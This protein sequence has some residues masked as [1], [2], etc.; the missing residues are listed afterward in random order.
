M[1]TP[2]LLVLTLFVSLP[3]FAKDSSLINQ[4]FNASYKCRGF[5]KEGDK[6]KFQLRQEGYNGQT[7]D[8]QEIR[9]VKIAGEKYGQMNL[10]S[11]QGRCLGGEKAPAEFAL[12]DGKFELVLDCRDG[13]IVA[14]GQCEA[15]D[16]LSVDDGNYDD[17]ERDAGDAIVGD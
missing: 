9:K 14:K 5:D 15:A 8:S 6:V 13:R 16:E 2:T 17:I 10:A 12:H 1:K 3:A 4:N 11:G 7:Y